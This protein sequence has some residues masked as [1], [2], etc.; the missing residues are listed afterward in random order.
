MKN[1]PIKNATENNAV[2]V[3]KQVKQKLIENDAAVR[4]MRS[5][6]GSLAREID[7]VTNTIIPALEERIKALETTD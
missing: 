3:L 5:L 6:A 7:Y 2:E 1:S 4:N